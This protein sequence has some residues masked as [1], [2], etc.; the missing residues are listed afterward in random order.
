MR[1]EATQLRNAIGRR[2]PES[3]GVYFGPGGSIVCE[4]LFQQAPIVTKP[5]AAV[6]HAADLALAMIPG[7]SGAGWRTD[8]TL[9]GAIV[10]TRE[11]VA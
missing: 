5:K 7:A 11:E 8:M 10:Q 3:H 6:G 2:L 9:L 4:P 1:E